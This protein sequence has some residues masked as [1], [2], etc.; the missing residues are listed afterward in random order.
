MTPIEESYWMAVALMMAIPVS[1]EEMDELIAE[2]EAKEW[3]VAAVKGE[4]Q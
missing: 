1:E 3:G 4:K 2:E